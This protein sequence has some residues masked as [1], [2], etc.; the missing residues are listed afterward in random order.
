M[1]PIIAQN[2]AKLS[3][4]RCVRLAVSGMSYRLLRSGITTAILA[5]AVAFLVHV[6]THAILA[7]RVQRSA[8]DDLAPSRNATALLTRLT[9]ADSTTNILERLAGK[10]RDELNVM[11]RWGNWDDE[12]L[13]RYR[14]QAKSWAMTRRW[15]E[16]LNPMQSAVLLEGRS[17][18]DWLDSMSSEADRVE[19][20][21]RLNALGVG[22]SWWSELELSGSAVINRWPSL[23]ATAATL[24][25]EHRATIDRFNQADGRQLLERFAVPNDD[26]DAQLTN[27]GWAVSAATLQQTSA[28][29]AY[30]QAL[31]DVRE[32]LDEPAM[33]Q[34]VNQRLGSADFDVVIRELAKPDPLWWYDVTGQG[35]IS[36]DA[37]G[38]VVPTARRYLSEQRLA[39]IT[40]DYEPINRNTP[41]GLPFGTLWLV[42][43]SLL[44]CVV[45][46]T[47]ALLMSVTERFNEIATMKCLGAMDRSIMQMFVAEAVIQGVLGGVVGVALGL[48]LTLL[49]G[50]AES[51]TLFV[52]GL[53]GW[54]D[55]LGAAGLSLGI[56]I[57]LAACAAIGPSWI[58]SRLA[59]MEAMRVE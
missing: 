35:G 46:V 50:F 3:V 10:D 33:Q 32:W 22:P 40:Q 11:K 31:A 5:L 52:R 58:A 14:E 49:R 37:E 55:L 25:Q 28:F 7:E 6:L 19:F 21:D 48:L 26:L 36:F 4:A 30:Q 13:A 9:A 16:R 23:K 44:V 34:A 45:G 24:Q 29:A 41:F 2:Q 18:V 57:L 20:K 53:D 56:G 1:K 15:F 42:G 51:G 12:E 39:A 17:F 54:A 27:A 47:N 38:G 59:P 8:W 43:L